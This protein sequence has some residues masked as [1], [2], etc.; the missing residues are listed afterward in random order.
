MLFTQSKWKLI[1]AAHCEASVCRHSLRAWGA[2]A[3]RFK[4][5]IAVW[6]GAVG[7]VVAV[8]ANEQFDSTEALKPS[9]EPTIIVPEYTTIAPFN[10]NEVT[11]AFVGDGK[12]YMMITPPFEWE[13]PAVGALIYQII[14]QNLPRFSQGPF[15]VD[16]ARFKVELLG[17]GQHRT[18]F[19]LGE[20]LGDGSRWALLSTEDADRLN[21][22]IKTTLERG[23]SDGGY[24]PTE[25]AEKHFFPEMLSEAQSAF[26]SER[27]SIQAAVVRF[28]HLN[29]IETPVQ[30]DS[31]EA[32]EQSVN[33]ADPVLAF[34]QKLTLKD[35]QEPAPIMVDAD[36]STV[37]FPKP[38][39]GQNAMGDNGILV[40]SRSVHPKV[41]E[42]SKRPGELKTAGWAFRLLIV[43]GLLVAVLVGF[44]RF[45]R[46]QQ[47]PSHGCTTREN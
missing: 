30:K 25:V 31:S 6:L 21:Q 16:V 27:E 38:A 18:L 10:F 47:S 29:S 17:P 3:Q 26:T 23:Y 33:A 8:E 43:G 11:R 12:I 46:R 20:W 15:A 42:E 2:Q 5:K 41:T 28:N 36:V 32:V 24:L 34:E 19:L 1:F 37:T 13:I 35:H 4:C 22:L 7:F 44:K 14:L 45:T 39:K 9:L 40:E